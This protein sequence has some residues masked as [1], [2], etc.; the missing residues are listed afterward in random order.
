MLISEYFSI[1]KFGMLRLRST[2]Y[3]R[4]GF[5]R[6]DPPPGT[7]SSPYYFI[8]PEDP[9][10]AVSN[11]YRY[12][13]DPTMRSPVLERSNV[14]MGMLLVNSEKSSLKFTNAFYRKLRD[15]EVNTLKRFTAVTMNDK[16]HHVGPLP[17]RELLLLAEGLN[18]VQSEN[19]LNKVLKNQADLSLVIAD[20]F[21][22]LVTLFDAQDSGVAL[23]SLSNTSAC[24]KDSKFSFEFVK[25]GFVP[26]GGLSFSLAKTQWHIGEFLALTS[27]SISGTNILYSGLSKRW[28]SP[29]AFPFME[30]ASEHKLDVSE[31]DANALLSEHFLEPPKDWVLRPYIEIINEVFAHEHVEDML[32]DLKRFSQS[33]DSKIAAFAT[34]CYDRMS[35]VSRVSLSLTNRLI[36][37]ARRHIGR[38]YSGIV[39]E[40]GEVTASYIQ[41]R[42]RL[43]QEH[44][45]RPALILS[46]CDEIRVATRM[47]REPSLKIDLYNYIS[48]NTLERTE[49]RLGKDEIDEFLSPLECEHEYSYSERS[50]FPLSANP[51]LRKF[52][53]DFNPKTGLDHDPVFM[54][55][56]VERWSDG[57][58]NDER[59]F[60][61]SVV[62]GMPVE[63]IRKNTC[64]RWE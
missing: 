53:P 44:I 43:Y 46:L 47:V 52:H 38:T 17:L 45:Q 11:E 32:R 13:D 3:V 50:D 23:A 9:L 30:V 14:G 24:Y 49:S 59:D 54:A 22:P 28:I 20:Y 4:T 58:L 48:G 29:E 5:F 62:T 8:D 2:A 63:E 26:S 33:S 37:N 6:S 60:I 36:K 40:Q 18:T 55:N 42:P 21:K 16:K 7:S 41:S 12:T 34:E 27:R 1:A 39:E 15:L 51:K 57:F 56:E 61:R 64:L 25:Y 35:S 31:K 19:Y 10:F